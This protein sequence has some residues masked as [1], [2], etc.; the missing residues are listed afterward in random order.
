M[1]QI[2]Y[3]QINATT[4]LVVWHIVEPE[5]YFETAAKSIRP[6]AHPHKRLQHVCGRYLL[7]HLVPFFP[8]EQIVLEHNNKPFLPSHP[9]HFSISHC[10]DYVAAIVSTHKQVGV[11]VETISPKVAK[12]RHKFLTETEESILTNSKVPLTGI[13]KLTLAWSAKEAMFK[14]L[15]ETGVDFREHL[16][17]QQ[18]QGE[19]SHGLI[20]AKIKRGFIRQLQIEFRL[21]DDVVLTWLAE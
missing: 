17:L 8:L 12:I 4:Q 6:I 18:L 19:K 7:Q 3:Q 16:N 14:W 11:D 20:V 2:F 1:P 5:S 15:G 13:E 21:L 10:D 9:Y